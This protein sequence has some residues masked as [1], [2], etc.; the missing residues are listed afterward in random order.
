MNI[1]H[2]EPS[3]ISKEEIDKLNADLLLSKQRLSVLN[4]CID[5]SG[6]P[7]ACWPW[8]RALN[9]D[10]Y[11]R[12]KTTASYYP[13]AHRVAY[14]NLAG[15]L[16]ME[17]PFVL[18]R[19]DN[20]PCCN[21]AHLF[22]GTQA[23]NVADRVKKGRSATGERSGSKTHPERIARGERQGTHT[24]PETRRRGMTHG[25]HKLT[26]SDILEIRNSSPMEKNSLAK[27][28]SVHPTTIWGIR[29]YRSWKHLP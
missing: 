11:G 24:K 1:T 5:K 20:P 3:L 21:P 13:I 16:T 14:R 9:K 29:T 26:D 19:C 27:K 12:F 10:G 18:H 22:L 25:N 8:T 28:Y 6:G 7:D 4:S 15:E 17:R 2:A 23:E